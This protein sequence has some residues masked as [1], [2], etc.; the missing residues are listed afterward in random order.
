M[1]AA[2]GPRAE[3][4]EQCRSAFAELRDVVRQTRLE[5]ALAR[6]DQ[7]TNVE[8]AAKLDVCEQVRTAVR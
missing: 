8:L 7:L 2:S 6:D 4:F 1:T 5:L 3:V